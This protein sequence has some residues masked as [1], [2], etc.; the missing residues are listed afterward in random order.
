LD[1]AVLTPATL[2]RDYTLKPK[3][4][5]SQKQTYTAMFWRF[6]DDAD[7]PWYMPNGANPRLYISKE[8]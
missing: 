7:N 2:V 3:E 4:A 8:N 5:F 6:G 1:S